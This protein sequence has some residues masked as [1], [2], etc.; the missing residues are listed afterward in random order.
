MVQSIHAVLRNALECAAREETIPR[1]VAKLVK[2]TAPSYQINRGLTASQARA[3]LNAAHS[4]RLGA[5]YVLALYLG[6]RRGE[7]FGLRWQDIDL[8]DERLEVSQNL[9]RVGGT[10]R[11]VPPKTEDS[12]RTVPLP[13]PCVKALRAHRENQVAERSNA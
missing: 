2:V 5:L 10:L 11:P 4:H 7:L 9:Q 3:V 8:G 1:N 6:L 13:A 12:R